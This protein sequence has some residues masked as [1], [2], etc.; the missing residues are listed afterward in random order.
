MPKS[1]APPVLQRLPLKP[2]GARLREGERAE[3]AASELVEQ[4]SRPRSRAEVERDQHERDVELLDEAMDV[5]EQLDMTEAY[6]A[7]E[8]MKEKLGE[9]RTLSMAQRDWAEKVAAKR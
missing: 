7:F 6:A 8:D 4:K 1:E 3:R 2:P 9:R 5:A